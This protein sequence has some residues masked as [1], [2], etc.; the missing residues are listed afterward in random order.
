MGY[1]HIALYNANITFNNDKVKSKL[2][3]FKYIK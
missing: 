2:L 1:F 3:M